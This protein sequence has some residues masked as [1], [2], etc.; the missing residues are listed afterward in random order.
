MGPYAGRQE[1]VPGPRADC[2]CLKLP[3]TPLDEWEDDFLLLADVSYRVPRHRHARISRILRQPCSVPRHRK[4]GSHSISKLVG[5]KADAVSR[6]DG[7]KNSGSGIPSYV[8]RER[9]GPVV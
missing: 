4:R 1:F 7:Y 3:G 2:K 8:I 6:W 9:P 5:A